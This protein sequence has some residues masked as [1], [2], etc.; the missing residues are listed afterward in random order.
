MFIINY[1]INVLLRSLGIIVTLFGS[2][3]VAGFILELFKNIINNYI[4]RAIGRKGVFITGIIGT[5]IH[6]IGH[7]MLCVL[8]G[9]KIKE[10]KI[11][12]SAHETVLGYVQHSFDPR[13]LYQ[14]VGN[15][16]IGIGPI[17]S[18]TGL[19]IL[20]MWLFLPNAFAAIG[21]MVKIYSFTDL[22]RESFLTDMKDMATNLYTL[23]LVPNDFPDNLKSVGF[24]IFIFCAISISSHMALSPADMKGAL[25]GLVFIFIITTLLSIISPILSTVL[26]YL[27]YYISVYNSYLIFAL[28]IALCC[29][30]LSAAVSVGLYLLNIVMGGD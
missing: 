3:I 15:F 12:P 25:S 21:G 2:I 29:S 22:F 20:L 13:S 19:I 5:P 1:I 16:F 30:L 11:F 14:R 8:F 9:H 23:I 7:A 10:M 27:D 28:F 18:G 6:E 26:E 24:W 4:Q 17:I